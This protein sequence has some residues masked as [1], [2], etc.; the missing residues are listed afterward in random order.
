MHTWASWRP[1]LKLI[2]HNM[3]LNQK[4]KHFMKIYLLYIVIILR[5]LNKTA[6][7]I[8]PLTNENVNILKNLGVQVFINTFL[9]IKTILH[10]NNSYNSYFLYLL[11]YICV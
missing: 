10:K 3:K 8:L 11:I 6:K 9:E 7:F 1:I 4:K 2:I 5:N